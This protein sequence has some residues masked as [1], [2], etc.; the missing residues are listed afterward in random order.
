MKKPLTQAVIEGWR[1][2]G[3]Q[4]VDMR[5]Y[6]FAHEWEQLCDL[7]L[8]G[9][10]APEA[11][12]TKGVA[13][14]AFLHGMLQLRICSAGS[15]SQPIEELK[16]AAEREERWCLKRLED[17]GLTWDDIS[18]DFREFYKDQFPPQSDTPK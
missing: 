13:K 2:D 6:I 12:A 9:L 8:K 5:R 4:G 16:A 3:V 1:R 18:A 14:G 7:A 17:Y 11:E 15:G 10:A